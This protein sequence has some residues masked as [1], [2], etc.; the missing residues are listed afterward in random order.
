MCA[1]A[2]LI[3]SLLSVRLAAGAPAPQRTGSAIA[4]EGR[5]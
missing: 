1:A 3:G 2:G 4:A 5:A